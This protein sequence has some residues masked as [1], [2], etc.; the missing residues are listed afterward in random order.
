MLKFI[1]QNKDKIL[2][3]IEIEMLAVKN[4]CHTDWHYKDISTHGFWN[5]VEQ[6]FKNSEVKLF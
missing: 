1:L 4:L 2:I 6:Y 5:I 3:C